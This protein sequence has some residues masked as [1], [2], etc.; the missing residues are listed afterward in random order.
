LKNLLPRNSESGSHACK[1]VRRQDALFIVPY[2]AANEKEF[3]LEFTT[4]MNFSQCQMSVFLVKIK[5]F[6]TVR[7]QS[8]RKMRQH[9][10]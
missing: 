9:G 6:S 10:L 1:D 2:P 4:Y 5:L 3:F 8:D 7:L